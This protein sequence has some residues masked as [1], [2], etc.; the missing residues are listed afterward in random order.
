MIQLQ[1]GNMNVRF[2]FI[3]AILILFLFNTKNVLAATKMDRSTEDSI[4]EVYLFENYYIYRNIDFNIFYS[5]FIQQDYTVGARKEHWI[6][7][8]EKVQF[9]NNDL[10]LLPDIITEFNL[11]CIRNDSCEKSKYLIDGYGFSIEICGQIKGF[12]LF[13]TMKQKD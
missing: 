4:Q 7:K 12:M 5:D 8:I 13:R 1:N 6:R 3:F 2:Y 11:L 9:N 10:F